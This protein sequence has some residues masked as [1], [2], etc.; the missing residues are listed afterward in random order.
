MISWLFSRHISPP[1][2]TPE[3]TPECDLDLW[4]EL[5][6]SEGNTLVLISDNKTF[7][8]FCDNFFMFSFNGVMFEKN[9]K[10]VSN[11]KRHWDELELDNILTKQRSLHDEDVVSPPFVVIFNDCLDN[12]F[13]DS[14]LN[15][16]DNTE[17]TNIRTLTVMRNCKGLPHNVF[18]AMDTVIVIG[19]KKNRNLSQI[20]YIWEKTSK[21]LI[22]WEE[23]EKQVTPTFKKGIVIKQDKIS[24]IILN[25]TKTL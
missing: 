23:F 10:Q 17:N 25:S 1:V 21:D 11:K 14:Y 7:S 22:E 13:G 6:S 12:T 8:R 2:E 24:T 20:K 19:K 5:F 3:E 9:G 4:G 18:K 15:C 16:I